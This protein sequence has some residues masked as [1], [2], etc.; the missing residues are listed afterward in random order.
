MGIKGIPYK[1]HNDKLTVR[2]ELRFTPLQYE[3]FIRLV[4]IS[5]LSKSKFIRKKLK[6]E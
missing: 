6:L 1:E 5:G 4:N 2:I 3:Q